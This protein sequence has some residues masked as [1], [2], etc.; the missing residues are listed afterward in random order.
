MIT[1]FKLPNIDKIEIPL[2]EVKV[3]NVELQQGRYS[4]LDRAKNRMLSIKKVDEWRGKLD[5][6]VDKIMNG[7]LFL[8]LS[9]KAVGLAK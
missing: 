1:L 3:S 4:T 9:F 6:K 5:V 8:H 7:D 2:G